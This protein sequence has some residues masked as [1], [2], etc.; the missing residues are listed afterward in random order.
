MAG[1]EQQVRRT[2]Q[3][4]G[5][6][7]NGLKVHESGRV[8]GLWGTVESDGDRERAERVVAD[9]MRVQVANHLAPR[10][11]DLGGAEPD[12]ESAVAVDAV[13]EGVSGMLGGPMQSRRYIAK[14]GDT[15]EK[16]ARQFY[17]DAGAWRR[18]L[19][20]NRDRLADAGAEGVLKTGTELIVP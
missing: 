16:V 7:V 9:T 14:P 20:A 17:G 19:D 12:E 1:R 8:L 5:I 18:V 11:A 4:R 13:L 15:L 2:L 10:A 6:S 3:E